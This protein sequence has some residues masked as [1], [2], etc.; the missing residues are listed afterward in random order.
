MEHRWRASTVISI[1]LEALITSKS[2][3]FQKW[4]R[5]HKTTIVTIPWG[6]QRV[7]SSSTFEFTFLPNFRVKF[8][9]LSW[10]VCDLEV[11]AW[12]LAVALVEWRFRHSFELYIT[13]AIS[14]ISPATDWGQRYFLRCASLE[15]A[16]LDETACRWK[17][18]FLKSTMK[19]NDFFCFF[20]H[21]SCR[22]Q[23]VRFFQSR[24]HLC[25]TLTK[26]HRE[27]F[28]CFFSRG[29][30]K[31]DTKTPKMVTFWSI[32]SSVWRS[33]SWHILKEQM[34]R[35]PWRPEFRSSWNP[36][37]ELSHTPGGF[38]AVN[39]LWE[40]QNSN[41]SNKWA[42]QKR[43]FALICNVEAC[44][45]SFNSWIFSVK[46]DVKILWKDPN[47]VKIN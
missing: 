42:T 32:L 16:P 28:L 33:E 41:L 20:L 10:T 43:W 47:F 18:M 7:A 36:G 23:T 2:W 45:R 44:F 17:E 25:Q 12:I 34:L 6:S 35:T 3:G 14:H 13:S 4:F 21:N 15:E 1:L 40:L 29:P 31:L 11:S 38:G 37:L 24:H 30:L 19:Y 39:R 9:Q 27:M 8:M 22:L 46:S 5:D 26:A